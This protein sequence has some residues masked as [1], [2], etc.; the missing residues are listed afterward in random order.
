MVRGGI[1]VRAAKVIL[2]DTEELLGKIASQIEQMNAA[3]EAT[4]SEDLY[5]M[6]QRISAQDE[7]DMELY[8]LVDSLDARLTELRVKLDSYPEVLEKHRARIEDFER[9]PTPAEDEPAKA[10]RGG[11]DSLMRRIRDQV[12]DDYGRPWGT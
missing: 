9:I 8:S 5:K 12:G 2:R 6:R 7:W 4:C 10:D 11:Q 1:S 3:L